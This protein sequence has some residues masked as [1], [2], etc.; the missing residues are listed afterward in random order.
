MQFA[1]KIRLGI[2]LIEHWGNVIWLTGAGRLFIGSTP[3]MCQP[4][5]EGDHILVNPR[6]ELRKGRDGG[7]PRQRV[8]E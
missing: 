6:L 1:I 3:R 5:P 7:E 2:A 4:L 8:G